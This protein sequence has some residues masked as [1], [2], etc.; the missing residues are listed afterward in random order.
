MKNKIDFK[1]LTLMDALDIA[2]L[3]EEESEQRYLQFADLI[4][5]RYEG[6]AG[7]FFNEMA[8]Y[9][10]LHARHLSERRQKLF[11]KKPTR[12]NSEMIWNVEAPEE[13]KPRPYMSVRQAFE[14][15][16]ESEQKAFDFFDK[17]LAHV[18]DKET[19][20]LFEELRGEE[21]QHKRTLT[22]KLKSVPAGEG[23]DLTDDDI[24]EPP[25][26]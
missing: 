3:I 12:V 20:A 14:I 2:I 21:A 23:P 16:I 18:T 19:H 17:A 15:A 25:Q 13:S 1:T 22:E 6:D 9:E 10:A 4:G 5:D 11:G 26:F 8:N 24:D 7:D